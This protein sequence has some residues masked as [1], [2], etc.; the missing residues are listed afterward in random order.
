M[1]FFLVL[2]FLSFCFLFCFLLSLFFFRSLFR[3]RRLEFSSQ[4]AEMQKGRL[5]YSIASANS[6][7]EVQLSEALHAAAFLDSN[8]LGTPY[9]NGNAPSISVDAIA[10]YAASTFS[11]SNMVLSAAGVSDHGAFVAAAE[12]AFGGAAAGS[13]ASATSAYGGG[14]VRVKTSGGMSYVALAFEV[15]NKKI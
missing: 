6:S 7:A 10:E 13:A 3:C 5:G 8:P 15:A 14:E 12:S 1:F 2:L 9:M 11:G 4:L